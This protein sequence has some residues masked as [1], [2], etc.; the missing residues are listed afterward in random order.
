MKISILSAWNSD[1]GAGMHAE[2]IGREWIKMG[3]KLSVFSFIKSDFHGRHF[4]RKDESYVNRCFGTPKTNF[5]D[6]RPIVKNPMDILIVED[7]GMLPKDKLAKFFPLFGEKAKT[8][9]IIHDNKLSPDPSFYQFNWDKVIVLDKRY[10]KIFEN[11]YPEKKIEIVPYPCGF[12]EKGNQREAR[13]KLKLPGD[14]KIIF[15]FGWWARHLVPFLPTIFKVG[16]KY[17]LLLLVVSK[18]I[19]VK[20]E[21]ILLQNEEIE[22]DF[23]EKIILPEEL[24]LY[25]HA[26]D[27]FV[28][29]DKKTEG[30]VVPSS[31]LM[32]IGAGCPIIAPCSNF[33]EIFDKEV[34]K[35]SRP[36]ELRENIIEVFNKG[37]KYKETKKAAKKFVEKNN[38]REIAKKYIKLFKKLLK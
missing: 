24:Y 3:H 8:I 4:L 34:L 33:F 16:R 15:I 38:P 12:W 10:K 19:A 37:E 23:R 9:N 31:A 13:R 28:F 36:K 1:S 32:G 21:Y 27:V 22:V 18:D 14:K 6:P 5:F 11:I 20:E 2:L 26:S 35:Y 17:P 7:L 29:G 25:L 30:V